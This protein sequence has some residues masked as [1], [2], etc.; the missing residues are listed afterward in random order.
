MLDHTNYASKEFTKDHSIVTQP[1]EIGLED[2]NELL[3]LLVDRLGL[4]VMKANWDDSLTI[5][6]N[7]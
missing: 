6:V 1:H 7:K 3:L 5:L 4:C 2:K